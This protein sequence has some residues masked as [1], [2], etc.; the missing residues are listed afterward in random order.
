[1]RFHRRYYADT[2]CVV[3]CTRCL[4]TLGTAATH[5]VADELE[6]QHVCGRRV[7]PEFS[8][9]AMRCYAEH[10]GREARRSGRFAEILQGPKRWSAPL[11]F[12]A[13]VVVVYGLPNLIEFLSAGY[14]SPWVLNVLFGDLTGCACLGVVLRM[15]RTSVVLYVAL[16]V[17]DGWLYTTGKV[18]PNTLAWITDAAP[19]LVVVG[20]V[21]QLRVGMR[22]RE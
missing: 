3:V 1:M 17:L 21:A 12:L 7:R 22:A 8:D 9:A 2:R 14:V 10:N 19:T 6:R 11:L 18:S 15:P 16:A 5:G 13:V 4:A 20:R